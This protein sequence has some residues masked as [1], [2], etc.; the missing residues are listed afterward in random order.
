MKIRKDLN[1]MSTFFTWSP[2]EEEEDPPKSNPSSSFFL[3]SLKLRTAPALTS[4]V[5]A[6]RRF[7]NMFIHMW[8]KLNVQSDDNYSQDK[9]FY[10]RMKLA[11]HE[12]FLFS[13]GRHLGQ[14][15]RS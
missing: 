15:D 7:D 6:M 11:P 13:S 3:E 8:L 1:D 5:T 2:V 4:K 14:I 12:F 9:G 10:R